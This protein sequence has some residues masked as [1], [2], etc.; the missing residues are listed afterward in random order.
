MTDKGSV[1]VDIERFLNLIWFPGDVRELRCPHYNTY[2]N[3]ASGYFD[4]PGALA[5]AASAWD[6]R[7]NLYVT[8]NPVNSSLLARAHNRIDNRAEHTTADVDILCRQWFFLDI[9][10][11]RP[12]GIS[13]TEEEREAALA[14]L[15]SVTSFL[16]S[17][18][19]PEP[20]TAM[21]GNGYYALYRVDLPNT[22]EAT[23]IIKAALESIASRFDTP[24]VRID[25]SVHNASRIV[26]GIGTMKHKGDSTSERPHRRSTLVLAPEHLD[27]VLE[28]LLRALADQAPK[29]SKLSPILIGNKV[30]H[31]RSLQEALEQK[32][33]E[34]H[35]QPPDAQ[36]FTWYHV[37]Q[38]PFHDDGR[39]FECGMGQKLPDGQYAGHCFH[40]EGAGK[41]WQEWKEALDFSVGRDG[42]CPSL[43]N[44]GASGAEAEDSLRL[45]DTWNARHFVS[46]HQGNILWCEVLKQ[47]FVYDGIYYARDQTREVERRA[48]S[49]VADLYKY[50]S[51]LPSANDRQKMAAWAIGSESRQRLANMIESAKRMVPVHPS[52]F[53]SNPLL[54]NILN[55][56]I[57]LRT[58]QLLP[59][60]Q[61]DYLTKRAEVRFDP[62]ADCPQWSAFL[63][64]IF[65][66]NQ[67]LIG[68]VQR[69]FGYCLTGLLTEHIIVILYGTGA[70]GKSTLLS[71]L[72]SLAGDYAYHCRPDVFTAK[73]NDSQGFEVVPLAGARVVTASETGAGRRLDE[74]LVKEMTG[75]EPIT[76]A[77]KYGDF[78]TFQPC[79]KPLLATN[80]KPE[81]R[82]V[83]EGIWRRVMLLP[84]AV[85]IPET[86]RDRDLS[87]K[88]KSE[89]SGIMNWTL[90]GVKEFLSTGLGAPDEVRSATAD[91]RV[92]QDVLANWIEERCV[93]G[94][95]ESDEYAGL[96]KDYVTWC[97]ANKEEPI[98]KNR[99]SSSLDERGCPARR[100]AKG[101]RL[102]IGIAQQSA[103]VTR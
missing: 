26:A 100:G 65:V 10:P 37:R 4:N 34:Y 47:W 35:T 68:F 49:T 77:P 43:S 59:H 3:T 16:S 24:A 38:C 6:G 13:S 64:R 73:R 67:S 62:V 20:A 56:T 99:F 101:K 71:V 87:C 89:L 23:A 41:G 27:I 11:V 96:Y 45:T 58:Q 19:W 36:G 95:Q 57:D 66:G 97:E 70:N 7:A 18:G 12:S 48:E 53:D 79:F 74:A 81:I 17:V 31:K 28:D 102:R 29:P 14:T 61:T 22:I 60:R 83:D 78:F 88:L 92:E 69:L 32:G 51:T 30:G 15:I 98:N 76:C 90:Q 46:D 25:T 2:G 1:R 82:G 44:H 84:F 55:G 91:Y 54:F 75:G 93:L 94:E 40:P 86:E 63:D 52:K 50:A 42:Q 21:S 80:H 9:D 5:K 8:L 85:T 39:P 72:R 103:G 33:I